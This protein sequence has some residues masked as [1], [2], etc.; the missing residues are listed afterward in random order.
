MNLRCVYARAAVE[1]IENVRNLGGVDADS[2]ISHRNTQLRWGAVP[3]SRRKSLQADVTIIA[4]VF[5]RIPDQVLKTLRNPAQVAGDVAQVGLDPQFERE[6]CF[7]H[8][9]F[10]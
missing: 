5:D 7:A 6:S 3:R 9:A 2:L 4:P 1:G 8:H 10:R